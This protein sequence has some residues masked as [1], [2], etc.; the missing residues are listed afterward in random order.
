MRNK[1]IIGVMIGMVGIFLM[2][3]GLF[4]NKDVPESKPEEQTT[5]EIVSANTNEEDK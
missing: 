1:V 4:E 5:T 2:F 3:N